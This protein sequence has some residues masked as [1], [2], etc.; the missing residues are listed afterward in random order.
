MPLELH[1]H[2]IDVFNYMNLSL[3]EPGTM[4]DHHDTD[5]V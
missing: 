3:S 4:P 1:R 2:I 5:P